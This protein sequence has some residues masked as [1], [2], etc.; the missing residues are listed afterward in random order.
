MSE[1]KKRDFGEPIFHCFVAKSVADTI[2]HIRTIEQFTNINYMR[3]NGNDEFHYFMLQFYDREGVH[4]RLL[5]TL[6]RW[7][8]SDE[9]SVGIFAFDSHLYDRMFSASVNSDE[10]TFFDIDAYRRMSHLHI[11]EL[12]HR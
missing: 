5:G 7:A 8:Q 6:N 10:P 4:A 3:I 12:Q 11:L 1:K 9:T 2:A